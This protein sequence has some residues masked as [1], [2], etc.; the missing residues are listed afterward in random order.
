MPNTE[1]KCYPLPK[2]PATKT[3]QMDARILQHPRKTD[4]Q[5]AKLPMLYLDTMAPLTFEVEAPTTSDITKLQEA[6]Q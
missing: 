4:K 6:L 1:R 3:S 2:V 5:L